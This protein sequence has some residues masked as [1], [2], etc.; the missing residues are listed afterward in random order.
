ME[1]DTYRILD[2]HDVDEAARVI[3]EAFIDDPLCAFML[4]TR[5]TRTRTL[6][7]FF[8]PYT[9]VNVKSKRAFGYG[10]PLEGVAFWLAPDQAGISISVRS[11]FS[12]LPLLISKYPIGYIRAR[13]ILAKID[14]LHHKHAVGRHFYLDNIGVLESARGKGASSKLIRPFL[15]MADSQGAFAYTDTVTRENVSLYEHFGFECVEEA[16]VGDTGITVWSL[17]RGLGSKA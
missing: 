15:E 14:E 2:S 16:P 6:Y 4:P 13:S 9:E 3:S 7:K 1:T 17:R 12:F 5:R 10:Q 8:R 11:L